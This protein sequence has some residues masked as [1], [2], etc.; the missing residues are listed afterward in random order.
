MRYK[1]F[2]KEIITNRN[3]LFTS[4]F[5]KTLTAKAGIK[6]RFS[7]AYYPETNKQTKRINK[8]LKQYLRHY[9]NLQQDNWVK[10]LLITELVINNII[11]SATGHTPFYA[12]YG[13]NPTIIIKLRELLRSEQA[14]AYVLN[15]KKIHNEVRISIENAQ[16]IIKKQENKH[17][18]KGL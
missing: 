5:W 18:K 1:G 11:L 10:L 8:T 6:V 14:I 13:R 2:P 15:L 17:K 12:N 4:K 3:K 7:T 9:V 16:N